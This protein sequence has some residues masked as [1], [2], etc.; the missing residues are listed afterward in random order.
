MFGLNDDENDQKAK[1]A[2]DIAA[3]PLLSTDIG[4]AAPIVHPTDDPTST[5]PP[6]LAMPVDVPAPEPT[7]P[8][9]ASLEAV[10]SL[11]VEQATSAPPLADATMPEDNSLAGSHVDNAYISSDPLVGK[12]NG[13]SKPSIPSQAARGPQEQELLK[14]KQ[15][16][17]H[18]LAPL[19]GHLEQSPEEKFKTT[20]MLIQA[21]DNADLVNEA[22]AAAG[23]IPD[24][25]ARAQAL[26]DVVNEINYFTQPHNPEPSS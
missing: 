14:L 19:V 2:Q 25:K 22:Y 13:D 24:E 15:E 11:A 1:I 10:P 5:M 16:A 8:P 23:K 18:H 17:L 26:L 7:P 20:M 21:S 12:K 3:D 9:P 6:P 4:S